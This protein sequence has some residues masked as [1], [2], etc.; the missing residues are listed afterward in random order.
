MFVS[1]NPRS[2]FHCF[3]VSKLDPCLHSSPAVDPRYR[4]I[5]LST[6]QIKLLFLLKTSQML[7]IA[8]STE[9]LPGLTWPGTCFLTSS[10][11]IL[12]VFHSAT[13]TPASSLSCEL[14]K[15]LSIPRA[16]HLQLL[17]L[18]CIC[19]GRS[20]H[21]SG[22]NSDAASREK[23]SSLTTKA[24]SPS[25]GQSKPHGLILSSSS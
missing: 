25:L 21:S 12:P 7:S 6:N 1:H 20:P 22:C 10:S 11:S 15:L 14:T 2:S 19:A 13:L 18:P 4:V 17:L 23:T 16:S 8:A 5:F 9:C 24:T 3:P